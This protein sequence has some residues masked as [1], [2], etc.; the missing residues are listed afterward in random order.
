VVKQ[1]QSPI[2]LTQKSNTMNATAPIE[3]IGK[4]Y[5]KFSL[6]LAITGRYL[7]D[8]SSDANVAMRLVPTR[9][10]NGEVMTADEAAI[11]IALGSLAG[12]DEATQQAVAA[13][14]TA[15]QSYIAAKGL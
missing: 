10:E 4:S 13:I 14:Q 5:D 1:N 7:G 15:L 6:N 8:G 3:I 12:S 9:I 2:F 11:G